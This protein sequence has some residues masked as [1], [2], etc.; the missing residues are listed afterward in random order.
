MKTESIKKLDKEDIVLSSLILHDGV[1]GRLAPHLKHSKN[2]FQIEWSNIVSKW[3]LEYWEKYHKAPGRLHIK[4]LVEKYAEANPEATATIDLLDKFLKEL[5]S[6]QSARKEDIGEQWVIDLAGKY[7]NYVRQTKT[8]RLLN[9]AHEISDEETFSSAFQEYKPVT[10]GSSNWVK[11]LDAKEMIRVL[12]EDKAG[13]KAVLPFKGALGDFLRHEFQRGNL[14][15]FA[16]APGKGK[17]YWLME[18]VWR[19]LRLNRKVLYYVLSD[20]S[21]DQFLRRF[22]VRTAWNP[23]YAGTLCIPKTIKVKKG[24]DEDGDLL[25]E[26]YGKDRSFEELN[27]RLIRDKVEEYLNRD[28]IETRFEGGKVITASDVENDVKEYTR[29]HNFPPDLVVIDYAD[30]LQSEIEDRKLD[31]HLQVKTSWTILKRIALEHDCLV[32]TATQ[33]SAR[34]YGAVVLK[35]KDFSESSSKNAD[36]D[37][38]LGINQTAK[39]KKAGVYR[40][41]WIKCRNSP[42][43]TENDVCWT[44]GLLKLSCPCIV[45]TL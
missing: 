39:E 44:A 36:A 5:L 25:F 16:G 3:C 1:L 4:H 20:L 40:L 24:K 27:E 11:I 38:I 7:F 42:E 6:K 31:R 41:N 8:L 28:H 32:L 21:K 34:G 29:R 10:F 17:S 9:E 33:I 18:A 35:Q 15:S 19:G 12:R 13:K 2:P 30:V 37:G 23:R 43:W 22:M 26:I 45:S 14:V